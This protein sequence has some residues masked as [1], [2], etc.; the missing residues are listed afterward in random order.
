MGFFSQIKG[1]GYRRI[2]RILEDFTNLY[3]GSMCVYTKGGLNPAKSC[4][5]KR[6]SQPTTDS[7]IIVVIIIFMVV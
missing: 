1:R 3:H 2:S 7:P 6:E 5:C 4:R